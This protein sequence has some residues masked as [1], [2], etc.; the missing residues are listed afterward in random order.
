[1]SKPALHLGAAGGHD[2]VVFAGPSLHGLRP[3][4]P[5][6]AVYLPPAQ[7]ADIYRLIGTSVR[8]ILL[9]DGI[10]HSRAAVWHREILTAIEAGLTVYGA[11]SM[12]ALR[13]S[14]LDRYGMIGVGT[15]HSWFAEGRI[16]GDDEVALLH[17]DE[18]NNYRP[19]TVPLVNVRFGLERAKSSRLVDDQVADGILR[20]LKAL[21]FFERT[22]PRLRD[23]VRN[24]AGAEA[25]RLFSF[26]RLPSQ[27][28]KQQ[29]AVEA[30]ELLSQPESLRQSS[31]QST[32][33]RVTPAQDRYRLLKRVFVS[34]D[35]REAL[36]GDELAQRVL[37]DSRGRLM[38]KWCLAARFFTRRWAVDRNIQAAAPALVQNDLLDRARS[39]SALSAVEQHLL[40][41]RQE[42]S[43]MLYAENPAAFGLCAGLRNPGLLVSLT[44]PEL[45]SLR[46][47]ASRN[48]LAG[49]LP[50]VA[51]WCAGVGACP[52]DSEEGT[53]GPTLSREA[54]R[55]LTTDPL[56]L[57][58]FRV[59][60]WAL[61]KGPA[62]FGYTSWSVRT[63]LL[64]TIQMNSCV[65]Q[66]ISEL[67]T[68]A[69]ASVPK[70]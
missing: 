54:L 43:S 63:E 58:N 23:A 31:G 35:R 41:E 16:N 8:R 36:D 3:Q 47:L 48:F 50:F 30:I 28:L 56:V 69:P 60:V 17:A 62:H 65:Q 49:A 10:F 42:L 12:G 51:G 1:V 37:E 68:R 44:E 13:S 21:P 61:A 67:Q 14:E 11:A 52:G 45:P 24:A 70:S 19:L 5:N 22:L 40:R 59:A 55:E 39:R 33:D 64:E 7:F 15:V 18:D 20:D 38:L 2:T 53:V 46:Q 25:E 66:L 57:D 4:L 29:D 26:L 27:D 34:E 32:C 9:I 6:G